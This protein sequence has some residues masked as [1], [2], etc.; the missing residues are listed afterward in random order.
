MRTDFAGYAEARGGPTGGNGGAIEISGATLRLT[1]S[2]NVSAPSGTIGSILLDP[3]SLDILSGGTDSVTNGQ[4][5]SVDSTV[6]PAAIAGLVGNVTLSASGDISVDSAVSLTSGFTLLAAGA[7]MVNQSVAARGGIEF[8]SG[9]T[10]LGG[11]GSGG[12]TIGAPVTATGNNTI[13]LNAG[14]AGIQL[15]DNLSAQVVDLSTTGGIT[16]A[17]TAGISATLLQSTGGV[18]GNAG[19]LGSNTVGSLGSFAVTAGR[20]QLVDTSSLKLQGTI[21]VPTANSIGLAVGGLTLRGGSLVAPGGTVAIAAFPATDGMVIGGTGTNSVSLDRAILGAITASDLVLRGEGVIVAAN[22]DASAIPVLDIEAESGAIK[23]SGGTLK[24]NTLLANAGAALRQA[25]GTLDA[26]TLTSSTGLGGG[27]TLNATT[28]TLSAIGSLDAGTGGVTLSDGTA[29]TLAGPLRAG[30]VVVS[31]QASGTAITLSGG[32][33]ATGSL[34][35]SAP[36]GGIAQTGG[37]ISAGTLLVPSA[38][39]DVV[40]GGS[41]NAI[42]HVG[43]VLA[44]G[45]GVTLGGSVDPQIAG[46]VS[47]ANISVANSGAGGI[48]VTG[49]LAANATSGTIDLSAAGGGVSAGSGTLIASTLTSSAGIGGTADLSGGANTIATLGDLAVHGGDLRLRDNKP[50]TVA[51][52]VSVGSGGTI[53]LADNRL[54]FAAGGALSAPN[55]LVEIGPIGSGVTVALASSGGSGII[56]PGDL[57]AITAGTLRLGT[58]D[59]STAIASSVTAGGPVNATGISTL[60]LDVTGGVVINQNLSLAPGGTLVGTMGSL[61]LGS[62]GNFIPALGSLDAGTGGITLSDGAALNL[63]G[64]VR[65]GSVLLADSAAGTAI[66][67]AG[68][69]TGSVSVELDAPNGSVA[70]AGVVKTPLLTSTGIGQGIT[71]SATSNSIDAIQSLQTTAGD[72]VVNDSAALNLASGSTIAATAG[73]VL[74]HDTASGP[75][76]SLGGSIQASAAG[77]LDLSAPNGGITQSG[78]SLSA[79]VLSSSGGVGSGGL[80]LVAGGNA[81]GTLGNV[82]VASGGDLRLRDNTSLTVAG[83]VSVGNSRTIALADN[84]LAFAAGGALSAPNGLVEIGPTGS[85][86]SVLLAF[87][88]FPGIITP[89]DLGAITAGTLRLGATDISTAVA[90]TMVAAGPVNATRIGTLELDAAGGVVIN[91]NLSLAAGGTLV[92]TM[93]SL[94]LGATGNFIPSL[95]SLD[96]GTGGVTLSD[97]TALTLAGPLR[98]G[99]VVVSDQAS[100]TAITLSGGVGATGSLS[101]SAPNGGIAQTGGVISAGTLLVPSAGGDVVLG[102][103]AN[104]IQH[105]GEVLAP[106]FGV[107]LGGSVDPQIAGLVSAAN[108]SVANSGAGGITVTGTLAANATSGTIDLSAAGGG[109]SAGSGTLIASTL[110][111]S[112][113]IGGTADLS[114][115]ANTIAALGDLAVHGGDLRLRDNTSLTVSGDV[116][117]DRVVVINAKPGVAVPRRLAGAGG[118]T[119]VTSGPVA[120]AGSLDAGTGALDVTASGG[121]SEGTGGVV[122][123]AT[124]TSAGGIGGAGVSLS[125]GNNSI[126][127]LANLSAPGGIAIT[128]TAPLAQSGLVSAG[129]GRI[130]LSDS[131]VG[132]A[133]TLGGSI[134]GSAISLA[135]TAAGIAGAAILQPVAGVMEGPGGIAVPLSAT[136][137]SGDITL[138]GAGNRIASVSGHATTGAFSLV[139]MSP[140]AITGAIFAGGDLALADT[141]TGTAIAV[142]APL[143]SGG[144]VALASGDGTGGANVPA[145]VIASHVSAPGL[146]I[147]TSTPGLTTAVLETAGGAVTGGA[148]LSAAIASGDI[149]L[150]QS[151][152]LIGVIG[153]FQ[154][155]RQTLALT[156]NAPLAITGPV[157]LGNFT[158]TETQP[159]VLAGGLAVANTWKIA[160]SSTI[161]HVSGGLAAGTITGSAVE[162][163]D[164]GTGD[165]VG[166]LGPFIMSGSTLSLSNAQ[167]LAIQGPIVASYLAINA[168][169][170]VTVAGNIQTNGLPVAQQ[171]LPQPAS[172]GSYIGVTGPNAVI[173]Q[174]GQTTVSPN[175]APV[176]TLRL[177][178]PLTGGRVVLSNLQGPALNLVLG[179]QG[180]TAT[181][182]LNVAGLTVIGGSGSAKLSG[183]VG[184][185]FGITAAQNSKIVPSPNG[186]YT[187]NNCPIQ[188]VSCVV[189]PISLVIPSNPLNGLALAVAPPPNNDLDI[190]LPGIAREDY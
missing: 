37:V 136:A 78:G 109:V 74:L 91:Q 129:S 132:T 140:L 93:G 167:P 41:A 71:L 126:H 151:G 111:S 17:P 176:A 69:L 165:L 12:I 38:G 184:S 116:A 65:G 185:L 46:L 66:T 155:P 9:L 10:A 35:L 100:G 101:L 97:G 73:N 49:T 80:T 87:P 119:L 21:S 118:V 190:L 60:E 92:G 105:V 81:I 63:A 187:L 153:S 162:L 85:G 26:V 84:A 117:V 171:T 114:G 15:N 95:G 188:A 47:A 20:F 45:F 72:V 94:V 7:V 106:G 70:G 160:S 135:S 44:P 98:A 6:D 55:G 56:A 120:V 32:V 121:F 139:D 24:A 43:E 163:A 79:G 57:G 131:A 154:A 36:N 159:L 27:V 130:V 108:I 179:I 189:L 127:A 177:Q 146:A 88:G 77:T 102:G 134:V 113:G 180:G 11:D 29:L 173:Y 164:F 31:D 145:I 42:Q 5:Y 166:T 90:A 142:D 64:P 30:N 75:A 181:G 133:L 182:N 54:A 18:A 125:S 169:G 170:Q 128:D 161:R 39:G 40:L 147:T 99:N 2:A 28:N 107:T 48:T 104:A 22:A 61:V 168:V 178:L 103:S 183:S 83:S 50:L 124:L 150:R 122:R 158:L 144:Q 89:G 110:T 76:I 112:A 148:T 4:T 23:L 156:D 62:A 53:A 58:T 68:S 137:T 82:A 1:G 33:G 186:N 152:N 96:A 157:T 174:M 172:P 51:G 8:G 138:L 86:V 141:A 3:G 13:V 67:L 123:A 25:G 143:T 59:L 175:G 52:T 19:L 149:D 115:G 14:S 16:Q 34:S